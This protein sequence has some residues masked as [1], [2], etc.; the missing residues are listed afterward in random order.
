MEFIVEKVSVNHINPFLMSASQVLEQVCGIKTKVGSI[1][2][3]NPMIDGEPLFIMLGITG[4]MTGQVCIVFDIDVA[5][6]IA[7]R[8]MMGMPV[9]EIDEMAKSA[10]SELGNMIMGNAATLL[11]NSGTLIDITPPTLGTG[12][13]KIGAPNMTCIKVPLLFEDSEIRMFFLLKLA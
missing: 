10:L 12:S 7:S 3:D 5:K 8:M 13:A 11:A 6:D 4:E 1:S 9:P 2:K